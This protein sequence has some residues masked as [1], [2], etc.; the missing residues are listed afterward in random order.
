VQPVDASELTRIGRVTELR[1]SRDGVRV[2]AIVNN[3]LMLGSIVGSGAGMS[4]RNVRA[5]PP[6]S[7]TQ[8]VDVDFIG[9]DQVVIATASWD[10]PVYE[11]SVDGLFWRSFGNSNLTPPISRVAAASARPVLVADQY[12]V[13]SADT[14]SSVWQPMGYGTNA[15]P[16]YPG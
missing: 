13:W 8:L 5:L 15:V 9:T 6:P 2:A 11:V 14:A 4:I 10:T 16:V 7:P 3:T 12:G 1:L